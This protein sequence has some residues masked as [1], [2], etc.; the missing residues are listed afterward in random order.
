MVYRLQSG[1]SYYMES[2]HFRTPEVTVAPHLW[3]DRPGRGLL[4]PRSIRQFFESTASLA[5]DAF[6]VE[7][8]LA[9]ARLALAVGT[10]STLLYAPALT[11]LTTRVLI[12][13]FAL[14]CAIAHNVLRAPTSLT[15]RMPISLHVLDVTWIAAI[16]SGT[17]GIASP[18]FGLFLFVLLE[19]AYRWGWSATVATLAAIL[20]LLLP[21]AAILNAAAARAVAA[22]PTDAL[23]QRFAMS[24]DLLLT[25][26]A[27]LTIG[28]LLIGYLVGREKQHRDESAVIARLTAAVRV[29]VGMM[30]SLKALFPELLQLSGAR[31]I[32][33]VAQEPRD[34]RLYLWQSDDSSD[35]KVSSGE[36]VPS[37]HDVYL[38][39]MPGDAWHAI[40]AAA[41]LR[42]V[43]EVFSLAADGQ[44]VRNVTSPLPDTF[45]ERHP[46]QSLIGISLSFGED[47]QDRVFLLDP[48]VDAKQLPFFLR[49]M[50]E[51]GPALQSVYVQ[52][53]MNSRVGEMERGRVA[54]E[55]HDRTVQSLVGLEMELA[56]WRRGLGDARS[57]VSQQLSDVQQRLR[58]EIIDLRE[59]MQ[60]LRPVH[61]E[62]RKFLS[63]MSEVVGRFQRETGIAAS[64]VSEVDRVDMSQEVC[65]GLARI[66]QEGLVNVRKHS[67]ARHVW[68][69]FGRRSRQWTLAI[70]DDGRGFDFK[71]R[72][73]IGVDS[74]SQGPGV[75]KER[76]E[77]LK[78][79]LTVE[80]DPARGARLEIT[81]PGAIHA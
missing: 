39:P 64:F 34:G 25:R 67:G 35:L 48:A 79:E 80:S 43:V 7:R 54:R 66:L 3:I 71:G 12:L 17:G 2:A 10:L 70:A 6:R 23:V 76:V 11:G 29:G 49:L 55:I 69:H 19:A 13:A 62:P 57:S 50:R 51:L 31:A 65:C 28:G 5:S 16:T 75:I 30:A 1:K 41:G 63:Y 40:R 26:T 47:W 14:Y 20:C 72:C 56:A 21:Q 60:Q 15:G 44:V 9:T 18:F 73:R 36:L 77:L 42:P 32:L 8:L 78:G 4:T 38:F 58:E 24:T 68:V 33:L 52:G 22:G 81:V 27:Y 37:E 61:T 59:L 45:A 46:F 53:R 74:E